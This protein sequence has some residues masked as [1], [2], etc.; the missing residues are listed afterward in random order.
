MSL[1]LDE[2]PRDPDRLLPMLQQMAEIIAQ[3]NATIAALRIELILLSPGTR[4]RRLRSRSSVSG[5]TKAR[6]LARLLSWTW[7][8]ER[9]AAAANA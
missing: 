8:S 2:L 6:E 4:R 9:L 3:Q 7:K 1:A 5:G